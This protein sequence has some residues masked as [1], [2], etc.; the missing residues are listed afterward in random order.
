MCPAATAISSL[1]LTFSAPSSNT[2]AS[3]SRNALNKLGRRSRSLRKLL[4]P[5]VGYKLS[6]ILF[7]LLM[8]LLV[9]R[10]VGLLVGS[11]HSGWYCLAHHLVN[12]SGQLWSGC[13]A[14][15]NEQ[16]RILDASHVAQRGM[17]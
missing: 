14:H 2:F 1:V 9:K 8:E 7:P 3:N 11:A 13:A 5:S 6:L 4:V 10:E 16:N 15:V 12:E 17:Q